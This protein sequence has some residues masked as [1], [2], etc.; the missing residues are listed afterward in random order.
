M[1]AD[2]RAIGGGV[3]TDGL[4]RRAAAATKRKMIAPRIMNGREGI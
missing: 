4:P 2:L 1:P 3:P